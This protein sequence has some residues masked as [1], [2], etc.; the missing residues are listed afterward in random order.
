MQTLNTVLSQ[1]D[2]LRESLKA[3]LS[4]VEGAIAS[5]RGKASI[6]DVSPRPTTQP[7]R[8]AIRIRRSRGELLDKSSAVLRFIGERGETYLGDA[9]AFA[10][11]LGPIK[12]PS[13]R[14]QMHGYVK[15][16][17]LFRPRPA[18]YVLTPEGAKKIGWK[19]EPYSSTGQLNQPVEATSASDSYNVPR[20]EKAR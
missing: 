10:A 7:Q 9:Q 11:T 17:W 20:R 15:K 14:T 4:Q 12:A 13:F 8:P 5:L 1:L 3:Q 18:Y 19:L 6:P 2:E 16:G